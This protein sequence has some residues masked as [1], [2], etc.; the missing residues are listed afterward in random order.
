M[1]LPPGFAIHHSQAQIF[2]KMLVH[3]MEGFLLPAPLSTPL[4]PIDMECLCWHTCSRGV[5]HVH[6]LSH[7]RAVREI[8]RFRWAVPPPGYG[9]DSWGPVDLGQLIEWICCPYVHSDVK[10][11]PVFSFKEMPTLE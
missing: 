9:P 4:F 8:V 10:V 2:C 6:A 11:M 1:V 7:H 5:H 3:Y